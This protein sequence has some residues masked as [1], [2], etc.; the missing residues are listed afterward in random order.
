VPA[1][2][3]PPASAKNVKPLRILDEMRAE[4]HAEMDAE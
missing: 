2:P 3:N 4:T 1:Q